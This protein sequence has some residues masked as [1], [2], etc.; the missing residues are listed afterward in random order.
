MLELFGPVVC[1]ILSSQA[2]T[3]DWNEAQAGVK[4]GC[5]IG[6]SMKILK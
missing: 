2:T 4:R 5:E 6:V 1:I 3:R